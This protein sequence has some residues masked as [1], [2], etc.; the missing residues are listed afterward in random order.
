MARCALEYVSVSMAVICHDRPANRISPSPD[1]PLETWSR[2]LIPMRIQNPRPRNR[3]HQ[4][5]TT[6]AS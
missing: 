2:P 4:L 3:P 5:Q 6:Q 1:P